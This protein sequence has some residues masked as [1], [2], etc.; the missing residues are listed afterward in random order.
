V[1]KEMREN[2][3]SRVPKGV[4]SIY[5]I[6]I[7]SWHERCYYVGR[8]RN[9]RKLIPMRPKGDGIV[10]PDDSGGLPPPPSGRRMV[11]RDPVLPDPRSSRVRYPMG[12]GTALPRLSPPPLSAPLNPLG[13]L[14]PPASGPLFF[15]SSYFTFTIPIRLC[16]GV[17]RV[18]PACVS[19]IGA[20]QGLGVR[21]L[22]AVSV[23]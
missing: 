23:C 21:V 1:A 17:F 6:A 10:S 8:Q 2:R 5:R 16:I 15:Q 13:H 19:P 18:Y 11:V 3:N 9:R 12:I 14:L 4:P 7:C 22:A 20:S